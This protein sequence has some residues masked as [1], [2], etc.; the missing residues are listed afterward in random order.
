MSNRKHLDSGGI[1][2][3]PGTDVRRFFHWKFSWAL[4]PVLVCLVLALMTA[5]LRLGAHPLIFLP[6]NVFLAC[7]L[8]WSIGCW[9]TSDAL[10]KR[11]P[12]KL[13][14]RRRSRGS[15]AEW[16]WGV[17]SALVAC[18]VLGAVG[19]LHVQSWTSQPGFLLPANDALPFSPCGAIGS[20]SIA[21]YLGGIV[22]VVPKRSFPHTVLSIDDVGKLTLTRR[23]D[24]AIAASMDFYGMNRK[25]IGGLADNSLVLGG[26]SSLRLE[27]P[28]RS[29]LVVKDRQGLE[30]V[31]LRYLN[32][33]AMKLEAF[34]FFPGLAPLQIKGDPQMEIPCLRSSQG[35]PEF[36]L[37]SPSEAR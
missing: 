26:N 17:S 5:G 12:K 30:L 29:T 37:H 8:I 31:R 9:L 25:K 7:A 36:R 13:R 4:A 34:L 21:L 2:S 28:D 15:Y 22:S 24:G 1:D 19:L 6:A 11:R 3:A 32:R 16:K 20:D 27:R 18:F 10:L 14:K 33:S 35:A 23:W